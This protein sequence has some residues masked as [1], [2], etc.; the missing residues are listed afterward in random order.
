[1]I[2]KKRNKSLILLR[3]KLIII[4][5]IVRNML[6]RDHNLLPQKRL[7]FSSIESDSSSN[8]R[9]RTFISVF[10]TNLQANFYIH[11]KQIMPSNPNT[12]KTACIA[13]NLLGASEVL[14]EIGYMSPGGPVMY[15]EFGGV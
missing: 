1:M 14:L 15:I 6:Q 12:T 8:P 4:I 3:I 9:S 5:K 7:L 13:A 11:H 10:Y 2:N